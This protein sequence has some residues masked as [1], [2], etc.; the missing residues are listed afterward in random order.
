MTIQLGKGLSKR[1]TVGI[2]LILLLLCSYC[3]IFKGIFLETK[4]TNSTQ[5]PSGSHISLFSHKITSSEIANLKNKL[6]TYVTGN[7]YAE[8][9]NGHGTGLTPPTEQGWSSMASNLDSVDTISIGASLPS[10]VDQ[11]KTQWFPPIGNQ[12]A[13]GSCV[14]WSVGYYMKTFQEAQEHNWNLSAATWQGAPTKQYQNQIMSPAF[15]YNLQNG[16]IDGGLSPYNAINLECF[17]GICSWEKMPYNQTDYFSWPSKEG[18]TEASLY[19]GNSSSIQY[20][21]LSTDQ[22][23]SNLKSWL[24]AGNLGSISID[25]YKY[26]YLTNGDLWTIDNYNSSQ[27]NHQNTI[28]G[29]ND[30]ISY[31]E[32]GTIHYGAF[33]VANSWGIGGW[34]HISD[35]FY[36]ISY[37]DMKQYVSACLIFSDLLNYTPELS[38]TFNISHSLRGECSIKI[39]LGNPTAPLFSKNFNQ[40]ISGG[41]HPFCQN[42]VVLDI[43]EFK[44]Y[45]SSIYNQTYFISVYD[46]SATNTIGTILSFSVNSAQCPNVPSKTINGNTIYLQVV[47][48]PSPSPFIWAGKTWTIA[49]GTWKV[50][51]NNLVGSSN[52]EALITADNSILSDY[53]VIANTTITS[54]AESSVVIRFVDTNN[55]YWMGIGCWGHQYSI[56]RMFNGTS[57][58]LASYG[59]AT[60]IQQN[61]VY[62]IKGLGNGTTLTLYINGTQMLQTTDSLIKSGTFGIRTFASS[63]QILDVTSTPITSFFYWANK[64][65]TITDGSWTV[66]SNKLLGSGSTEALITAD[67]T[68]GSNYAI[69]M[70]TAVTS[71][72]E[73]SVVIRFVDANNFYWMGIGCWGHLYAIGRMLDGVPSE[74]ASYGF[75]SDVQTKTTYSLIAQVTGNILSFY[76]NGEQVLQTSDSA[77]GSGGYGVRTF[78][79]SVQVLDISTTTPPE[80]SPTP[81]PSPMSIVFADKVWTPV[82]GAWNVA[83][84]RLIGSGS[85]EAL[86]TADNSA[87]TDYEVVMSTVITSGQEASVVIRFI[88]AENFYWIGIGCWGHLYSIGRMLNGVPSE[89][90]SYGLASKVQTNVAY[91]LIAEANGDILALYVN[92]QQVL[93][94]S[95]S[96]VGSGGYGVRTFDSA[97]QIRDIFAAPPPSPSPS[98]TPTLTPSPTLTQTPT[99]TPSPSPTPTLSPTPTTTPTQ[100]I[101]PSPVLSPTPTLKSTVTPTS[102]SV[103]IVTP[104]QSPT[105]EDTVLPSSTERPAPNS[106]S[107]TI[108]TGTPDDKISSPQPIEGVYNLVIMAIVVIVISVIVGTTLI[109]A[110]AKGKEL[111]FE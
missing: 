9:I 111:N 8:V 57:I 1:T 44:N 89:L 90:A 101:G 25:A 84:N 104:T 61:Y 41:N 21:N 62:N 38:A 31:M 20:I 67:N 17:V 51:N 77:L 10:A 50:V 30:S 87:Y 36:W 13:Q 97:V 53:Y 45:V 7:Y 69:L 24:V 103:T 29:Y 71:G 100:T 81:K 2:V 70:N 55:F 47:L 98:P 110:K 72:V 73:S 32:S 28:V 40:Y 65:W 5:F 37:Q 42:D 15:V 14:A 105:D 59:L 39:G 74:L 12:G 102:T 92:G 75:V 33:K 108:I 66:A 109:I 95:D 23:I 106:I 16:G 107:P 49:D 43:T 76:V 82:D 11:S 86:I 4:A 91:S 56:G 64:S 34:E 68:Y 22:G 48:S 46:S 88:D 79:S 93:Q 58:E 60:D 85:D 63:V 99:P 3:T 18:W 26:P 80:P 83:N 19:R 94:T 27:T 35:G 96:A 6:G 54:G 78:S 52:N